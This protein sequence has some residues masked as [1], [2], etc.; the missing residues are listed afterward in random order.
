MAE[1]DQVS[2]LIGDI[3]D[4]SLDPGLWPLALEKTCRYVEGMSSTLESHDPT[5][6]R[7]Q[8]QFEWGND[9]HYARL[10]SE[11]YVKLSPVLVPTLLHAQVGDVLA[12]ADLIPYHEFLASRFYKEW[13]APQGIVDAVS[14]TLDKSATSF[15]S[16]VVN[17]HERH[18]HIDEATRRRM[19]VL[20]P[21][22]RRA[23][24][25]GKAIDLHK[26]EAATL[27]D[28]LDALA[29]GTFLVDAG[30]RVVHA[31][32]P[33][34]AML[35]AGDILSGRGGRLSAPEPQGDRALHDAFTAADAGDA[36]VGVKGITVPLAT[37]DGEHWVAH[38]LPLTSGLRREAG[39]R[40]AAAAAVFVRKAA[41]DLACPLATMA[42][43][44]Q[45]TRAEMRVLI[46]IV[47]IGGVPEV[48]PVLGISETTVKTHLQRVFEKT[49]TNRQADLVKLIAGF[50]NPLG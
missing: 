27:A 40:H 44:Y 6:G 2:Q 46:A 31:N 4:A 8:Y 13:A 20:A 43:L 41:L 25:V 3:Y 42:E 21:H 19:A 37:R 30:G 9:P 49:G 29:T 45:L 39:T 38:V 28:S 12:I 11:T 24:S 15:A 10:Y 22:F 26:V 16:I 14:V 35:A 36:A 18:G 5:E 50:M 32:A 48:A 1:A 17:R 23:V 47:E 33:G 34:Q 7:P